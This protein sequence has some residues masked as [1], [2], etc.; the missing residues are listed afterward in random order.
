MIKKCIF[1]GNAQIKVLPQKNEN[2]NPLKKTGCQKFIGNYINAGK[3]R[4]TWDYFPV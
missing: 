1:N 2:N 3:K 4:S